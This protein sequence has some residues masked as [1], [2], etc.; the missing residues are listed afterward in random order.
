MRDFLVRSYK[1]FERIR[2]L[3]SRENEPESGLV[4]DEATFRVAGVN[5]TYPVQ[6]WEK[7]FGGSLVKQGVYWRINFPEDFKKQTSR[8]RTH[9]ALNNPDILLLPISADKLPRLKSQLN[10]WKDELLRNGAIK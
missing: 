3:H 7:L 9:R 4:Y 1:L 6:V 2:M 8:W 10:L 5:L